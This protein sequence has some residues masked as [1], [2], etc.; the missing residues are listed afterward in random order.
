MSFYDDLLC[1][2]IVAVDEV[3]HLHAQ[4]RFCCRDIGNLSYCMIIRP[5][6]VAYC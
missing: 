4:C 1:P 3:H 6:E 5:C 2:H